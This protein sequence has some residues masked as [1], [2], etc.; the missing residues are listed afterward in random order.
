V[1]IITIIIDALLAGLYFFQLNAA[2]SVIYFLGMIIQA[3]F[4]VLLLILAVRY[5]GKKFAVI[6]PHF[7]YRNISIRYAIIIFSVIINALVLFLYVLNY[8][9]INDIIFSQ[10]R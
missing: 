5:R 4:T 7:F 2:E 10:F 6:Q 8:L 9:G 3:V 1:V